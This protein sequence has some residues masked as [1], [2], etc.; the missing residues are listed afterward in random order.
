MKRI[1]YIAVVFLLTVVQ[2]MGQV[3]IGKS[4]VDG[5]GLLDFASGTTSG[6]I[7][8]RV[9]TL[10]T[11]VGALVY[12]STDQKVKYNNGSWQDL[13]IES[14][15]VDMTDQNLYS[16][17]GNG[18]IIGSDT[19]TDEGVLTL[20]STDKALILPKIASPEVNVKSPEAGMI[21][22]DTVK[23]NLVVYNGEEWTFW[24]ID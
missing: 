8:P 11:T 18:V 6:I 3:S 24:S 19:T 14:G 22:Y 21:C 16:D 13:S 5:D 12:D 1:G 10:P 17:V 9:T 20:E 7:L 2:V 23:K 4:S 15:S